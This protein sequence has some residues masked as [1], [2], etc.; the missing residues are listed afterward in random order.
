[1]QG[2]ALL[3]VAWHSLQTFSLVDFVGFLGPLFN[4]SCLTRVSCLK[5]VHVVV[6][7]L[8]SSSFSLPYCYLL[9]FF[10]FPDQTAANL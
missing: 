4:E 10:Q 2:N 9:W 8:L 5:S 3:L 1:M 7:A 6:P